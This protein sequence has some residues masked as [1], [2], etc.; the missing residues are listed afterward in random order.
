MAPKLGGAG[1]GVKGGIV[2]IVFDVVRFGE[3]KVVVVVRDYE[4]SGG[5]DWFVFLAA[6]F[7]TGRDV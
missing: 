4:T 5:E 2:F 3:G 1:R 6:L 7:G